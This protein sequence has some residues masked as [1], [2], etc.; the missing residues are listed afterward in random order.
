MSRQHPR[1]HVPR[2]VPGYR[3]WPAEPMSYP[4]PV[5][6]RALVLVVDTATPAVTAALVAVSGA[7]GVEVLAE[8]VR[9][10]P[11]RHGELLA[12][13]VAAVLTAAGRSAGELT[14]VVAGLG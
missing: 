7:A 13:A 11:R 4:R 2:S 5:P 1:R 10:D 12:P 8:R 9:V 6:D 3:D 14:A